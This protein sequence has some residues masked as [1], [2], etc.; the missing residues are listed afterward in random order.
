L[1]AS[2]FIGNLLLLVINWPLAGVW[3]QLL[4]IPAPYLYAGIIT[5]ALVGAYVINS[6]NFDIWI[7]LIIGTLGLLFRRF[8]YPITPLILGVI[9]GPMAEQEF[10]R[11]LQGAAGDPAVLVSTPFTIAVY[12]LLFLVITV[13]R[14]YSWL[15]KTGKIK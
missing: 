9:L 11:A 1:I 8:G 12:I 14:L 2:L 15:K 6:A 5:F 7:A 10:R 3:A 13:P 4:R